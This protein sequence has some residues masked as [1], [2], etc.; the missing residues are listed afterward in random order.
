MIIWSLNCGRSTKLR[1]VLWL[2]GPCVVICI[3]LTWGPD[4]SGRSWKV[5]LF[6]SWG[7]FHTELAHQNSGL[8][9]KTLNDHRLL[10]SLRLLARARSLFPPSCSPFTGQVRCIVMRGA[11]RTGACIIDFVVPVVGCTPMVSRKMNEW[12]WPFSIADN[13]CVHPRLSRTC[14]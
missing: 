14:R 3:I 12:K 1:K 5:D 2:A 10:W 4:A 6:L 13:F 7:T 8:K 11:K 9:K